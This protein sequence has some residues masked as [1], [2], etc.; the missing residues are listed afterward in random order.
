[1]TTQESNK[2]R[3]LW[4][5]DKEFDVALDTATWVEM[6]ACL[7]ESCTVQLLADYRHKEVQPEV[8]HNK[9]VY[10][11]SC[12]IPYAKCLTRYVSQ[13]R[14]TR[15]ML[16]SYRPDIVLFQTGNPFLLKYAV[17]VR[18]KYQLRLVYDIRTLPVESRALR[19]WIDGRLLSSCMRYA[20]D[21]FDG[22]TYITN[23]M[24]QYC[25]DKYKLHPHPSIV[26]TSGVNPGLFSPSPATS[27][28]GPFTIMYHGSIAKQR[29]IDNAVK[30]IS[31]LPDLDI[32]LVLLGTGDG[33]ANL[34]KLVETLKI[35]NRVS[36]NE[37]VGYEEVPKWIGRCDVGILPFQDWDGWN[38]SSPIKLFEYLAC[39][40]PV[41]VTDI[42]AHRHVLEDHAFAFWAKRS[43]P[44]DI[45]DAIR[46]AY[47][48][49]A[50]LHRVGLKARQL[51]LDEYTWAKQA[52]RLWGFLGCT[53][54]RNLFE[55]TCSS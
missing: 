43:S 47:E 16:E 40:K 39:A 11:R 34:R 52:E 27:P 8:F 21:Y 15:S 55:T 12:R 42:P 24:K 22:M 49:R 32:R 6:V 33:L 7:Q 26:W 17:S 4:I 50:D 19:N 37:P 14:I 28:S 41:I 18:Q 48:I 3:I 38:V 51:V 46:Q 10:Y 53:G 5:T 25:I 29:M 44:Q 35:Q 9:I 1:M 31:L 13:Y 20:A 2:V 23:Q 36:F 54:P 45:A 30:A